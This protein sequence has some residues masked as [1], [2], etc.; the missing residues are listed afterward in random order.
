MVVVL[1][2]LDAPVLVDEQKQLLELEAFCK[3]LV[4]KFVVVTLADWQL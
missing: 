3:V 1:Q 4:G 2:E